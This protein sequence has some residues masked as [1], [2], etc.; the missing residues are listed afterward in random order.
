MQKLG[1]QAKAAV[2]AI[3]GLFD[4][5]DPFMRELAVWTVGTIGPEAK[6]A[7]PKLIPLLG[8]D[9]E[10]I[11]LRASVS[12]GHIGGPA[13]PAALKA[14]EH[15]K[16]LVRYWAAYALER[17]GPQA[18]PAVG[19]LVDVLTNDEDFDA[20]G[21]AAS[22][23]GAIGPHAAAQTALTSALK[24]R[25]PR[26]RILAA[27]ALVRF[28]KKPETAVALLGKELQTNKIANLRK[29]AAEAVGRLGVAGKPLVD[30]LRAA[31]ADKD[32][33]VRIAVGEALWLVTKQTDETLPVLCEAL[34]DDDADSRKSAGEALAKI[35]PAAKAAL[36]VLARALKDDDDAVRKAAAQAMR[37]IDPEAA[38]KAGVP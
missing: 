6:A 20:R 34:K 19:A 33:D 10:D 32:T 31:L 2:P 4:D 24:D 9:N 27:E 37:K 36:P 1:P 13:V 5:E 23:L 12:L 7:V 21:A 26:V 28:E 18:R 25:E 38:A 30:S 35:G 8:D 15:K 17:M 22:A 29:E 16:A 11:R 3:L 14:L